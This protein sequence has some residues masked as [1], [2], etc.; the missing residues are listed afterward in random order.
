VKAR[1]RIP[2]RDDSELN[3]T[4]WSVTRYAGDSDRKPPAPA[5][6]ILT[7]DPNVPQALT[8]TAQ[9]VNDES[10]VE[11]YFDVDDVSTPGGHDSGWIRTRVYTDTNLAPSTQYCYRVKA[12]DLSAWQNATDWSDWFCATTQAGVDA[13]APLPNPPQWDPNGLPAEYYG[14]ASDFDW[15]VEMAVLAVTDDSGGPVWYFFECSDSRY[16]SGWQTDTIWRTQIGR[17]GQN[18]TWRVRAQDASGNMTE[19][20]YPPE[21]ETT[22]P[23]QPRLPTTGEDAVVGG[24]GGGD[25]GD[26]GVAV[27]G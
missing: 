4:S 18:W 1:D 9:D 13:N 19:W 8:I 15:W 12:R 17:P 27:G 6:R 22:R 25:G 20:T 3:E 26:T 2:G 5:P 7:I 10:G 14:F 16:S 24:G 21:P 23:G 11:Y